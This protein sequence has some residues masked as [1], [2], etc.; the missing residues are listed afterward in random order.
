MIISILYI[1]SLAKITILKIA[2]IFNNTLKLY[3]IEDLDLI[4][5]KDIFI[6]RVYF[7]LISIEKFFS[8]FY[9]SI[10]LK[11]SCLVKVINKLMLLLITIRDKI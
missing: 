5:L 11:Q 10:L 7:E 1:I 2:I 4:F 9:L 8:A 3:L 6:I